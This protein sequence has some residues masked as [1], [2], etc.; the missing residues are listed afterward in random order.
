MSPGRYNFNLKK[1]TFYI[2]NTCEIAI[3]DSAA[4]VAAPESENPSQRYQ[5]H[6]C[7]VRIKYQENYLSKL[8]SFTKNDLQ[9]LGELFDTLMKI[10]LLAKKGAKGWRGRANK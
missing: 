8:K 9:K 10:V 6:T 4:S 5:G 3:S 1:N 7:T 2:L